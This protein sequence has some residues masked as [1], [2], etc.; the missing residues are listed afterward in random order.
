MSNSLPGWL[1]YN[2]DAVEFDN[3]WT[4]KLN[5]SGNGASYSLTV[6]S[7]SG[8]VSVRYKNVDSVAGSGVTGIQYVN[9]RT[10][11]ITCAKPP[12]ANSNF[13]SSNQAFISGT[14]LYVYGT[15]CDSSELL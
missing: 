13:P 15:S 2:F 9:H 6:A 8:M 10:I 3:N 5:T 12:P 1:A 4:C 7:T 11:T 14:V